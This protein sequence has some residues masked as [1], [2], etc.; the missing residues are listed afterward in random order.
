MTASAKTAAVA[1]TRGSAAKAT[2]RPVRYSGALR[3]SVRWRHWTCLGGVGAAGRIRRCERSNNPP[4]PQWTEKNEKNDGDATRRTDA[5]GKECAEE[6]VV[7]AQQ[8]HGEA[9][10]HGRPHGSE[11]VINWAL[12]AP[13][14]ADGQT[15]L[16]LRPARG[17]EYEICRAAPRCTGLPRPSVPVP[18]LSPTSSIH[19][20]LILLTNQPAQLS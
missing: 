15:P 8:G 1:M 9:E 16:R 17:T 5:P 2:R 7:E 4:N 3:L 18:P 19:A 11:T 14:T 20:W 6:A 10:D 12:H 13:Q